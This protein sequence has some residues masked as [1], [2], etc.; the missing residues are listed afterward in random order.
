MFY[1]TAI[2][3]VTAGSPSPYVDLVL[4]AAGEPIPGTTVALAD[5]WSFVPDEPL[6]PTST[7]QVMLE[8]C[9]ASAVS[10]TT[11][12]VGDP[13]VASDLIGR[14]YAADLVSGRW[15]KPVGAGVILAGQLTTNLLAG[16]V[17]ADAYEIELMGAV[18]QEYT[19]I[20]DPCVETVPF[21]IADFTQN[22]WFEIGPQDIAL[23]VQGYPI[24][25]RQAVLTGAFSP[26]LT[27]LEGLTIE[28][29]MDTRGLAWGLGGPDSAFCDAAAILGVVCEPCPDGSGPYCLE[30]YVDN[31]VANEG[32]GPLVERDPYDIATDPLCN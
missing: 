28:G 12:E 23:T 30:A 17:H 18:S 2:E 24:D 29:N 21:P 19:A 8:D 20:Q 13:V 7:Y 6:L 27:R 31:M 5:R 10:W 9:P 16:V 14:V 32:P 4:T 3:F 22:P 26:D 15:V 11:S 1:R 25:I